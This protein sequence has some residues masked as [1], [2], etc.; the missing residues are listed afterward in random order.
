MTKTVDATTP[1]DTVRDQERQSE[2]GN[3]DTLELQASLAYNNPAPVLSV[4]FDGRIRITNPA[5]RRILGCDLAGQQIAEVLPGADSSI[6]QNQ[7][8]MGPQQFDQKL[9]E[10]TFEFT[11][12]TLPSAAVHYVYGHDITDR[13][14]SEDALARNE[15]QL[16]IMTDSIQDAVVMIDEAG[17]TTFWNQAAERIFGYSREEIIG[18]NLY[19]QILP[20]ECSEAHADGYRR[21]RKPGEG[22]AIGQSVQARRKDGTRFPVELT[23]SAIP[24]GP[25]WHAVGI[26]R[27]I[28]ERV[29]REAEFE[30]TIGQYMAMT[31]AVPA[32]AFLKDVDG[33]YVTANAAFCA[34]VKTDLRELIGKTDDDIP[35]HPGTI[36]QLECERQVMRDG[37]AIDKQE[38]RSSHSDGE[39][40]WTI[41]SI[42]PV[43]GE[44]GQIDGVVGLIQ[45]VTELHQ[46][47][48]QLVQADKMA[49]IGTLSAGVAHEINNPVGFINSN[50]NTMGKYL[51]KI[52][53]HLDGNTQL[54][55]EG[56]ESFT[57]M[58]DD[59][60]DAIEESVD[61]TDR[62]KKI[63]ADLKSF[64]RV[65]KAQ[66]ESY[67]L[68][69]GL[70]TTLNIVWNELKYKCT[71]EKNYGDIPDLYCIPN[72]LNQVFMNLLVNAGHAI[73]GDSGRITITTRADD[74]N[75]YISISDTGVGIPPENVKRIFEPFYTTKE[76]GKGTGLGLSMAYDIVK[77]HSGLIDVVSEVGK[78]TEFTLTLPLKGIDRGE[79]ENTAG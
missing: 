25:H 29:E 19:Q 8:A 70:E 17:N 27:D 31:N 4:G 10:G 16:R 43:F 39:E 57:E 55:A 14:R 76:V 58:L 1:S 73:Q 11:V 66:T 32:T 5:A 15:E 18:R 33:R 9:A 61:G 41:M 69:E 2:S 60:A 30:R 3:A 47:R 52:R 20:G 63:V 34:H 54:D 46:S 28:S 40:R 72:Q 6:W 79:N 12:A 42:V 36:A 74:Q 24:I 71:V 35:E 75:I 64:S 26:V 78:G 51:K 56:Q 68:I 21:F 37:R 65:D 45:D 67:N 59:F 7:N 50:L 62:V 49:A 77:K 23:L 13:R 48:E 53:C 22:S 44:D 38:Q